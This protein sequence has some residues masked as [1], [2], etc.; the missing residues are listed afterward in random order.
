[1]GGRSQRHA[2][3]QAH[4]G[5]LGD[6]PRHDRRCG[7]EGGQ[8]RRH[9]PVAARRHGH[10]DRGGCRGRAAR[11]AARRRRTRR[12]DRHH[13]RPARQRHRAHG[14]Q[15]QRAGELSHLSAYRRLRARGAGRRAGA[16]GDGGQEEAALPA[17]A[18]RDAGRR[19]AWPHHAAR[20]DARSAGQGRRVREGAGH[21][22]GQHPGGLHLGRHSLHR[23]VDRGEPRARRGGARQGDR[24]AS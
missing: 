17:G 22:C 10:R 2:L 4:P 18:A 7:E 14:E 23:P 24:G 6:D 12:A 9:L 13:P 20:P 8:A 5:N 16:G 21:R 3:G 11:A 15:R 19:R 1:M